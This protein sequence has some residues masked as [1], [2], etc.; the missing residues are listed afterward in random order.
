MASVCII[1]IGCN[2]LRNFLDGVLFT[3]SVFCFV[4]ENGYEILGPTS[5]A[6]AVTLAASIAL[7]HFIFRKKEI[8]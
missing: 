4:R 2:L 7:T 6:A 5:V 1:F 8:R 3:R